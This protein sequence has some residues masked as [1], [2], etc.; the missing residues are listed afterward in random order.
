[1]CWPGCTGVRGWDSSP[2]SI[3]E[4]F[5]KQAFCAWGQGCWAWAVWPRPRGVPA[6]RPGP[7][8][9]EPPGLGSCGWRR[10]P[11]GPAVTKVTKLCLWEALGRT[12]KGGWIGFLGL[13]VE[14]LGG[15]CLLNT[16]KPWVSG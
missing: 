1:M 11:G 8:V 16:G 9:D 14:K 7:G 13:L 5:Q 3:Q 12:Q 4:L 10:G 15:A 2:A 6:G